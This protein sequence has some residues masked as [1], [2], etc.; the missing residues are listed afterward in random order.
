[1]ETAA[2]A[3]LKSRSSSGVELWLLFITWLGL[4]TLFYATN[5]GITCSNDGSQ[6]ALTKSLLDRNSAELLSEKRFAMRDVA[7]MN[8][9]IFSDRPPGLAVAYGVFHRL[10]WGINP[11]LQ[12][13]YV[14]PF[15]RGL[16][17]PIKYLI[18][19]MMIFP[20]LCGACTF[21]AIFALLG[22]FSPSFANR[23]AVSL[24]FLLGTLA[25]R[26]STVFYSHIFTT[27]LCV[28]SLVFYLKFL[29]SSTRVSLV[30]ASFL[31]AYA[32]I[33]EYIVAL[34]AIPLVLDLVARDRRIKTVLACA[35]GVAVP[36]LFFAVYNWANFGSP[37]LIAHF[38][39]KSF[40]YH[41]HL[42]TTFTLQGLFPHV[43]ELLFGRQ[44]FSLFYRSPQLTA[45]LLFGA[46]LSI[47]KR[48]A[49]LPRMTPLFMGIF[50][51]GTISIAAYKGY[52][53]GFDNDYRQMLF[54]VPFIL[55]FVVVQLDAL[56]S[57]WRVLGLAVYAALSFFACYLQFGHVRHY[58][59]YP[60][61]SPVM[62]LQAAIPNLWPFMLIGFLSTILLCRPQF[63]PRIESLLP[64]RGQMS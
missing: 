8:D 3:A 37:F 50:L 31:F 36:F 1:M 57:K 33:T 18:A 58:G 6:L 53:G 40:K 41:H 21:L 24:S 63:R 42:S 52:F 23:Y 28:L 29:R 60:L 10:T 38:F 17:R 12:A 34:A 59:Q 43:R 13:I 45:C 56:S 55:P 4:F 9:K 51:I 47:Y 49:T 5:V 19:N 16:T 32:I 27:L 61:Y 46:A 26:Y 39:H 62:N 25:L 44:F 54:A 30:L 15:D 11:S 48:K 7:L 35:A 20:A 14:D 2:L 22:N 64:A